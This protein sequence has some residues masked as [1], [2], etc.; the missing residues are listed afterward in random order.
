MQGHMAVRILAALVEIEEDQRDTIFIYSS[1]FLGGG[2]GRGVGRQ[3]MDYVRS[4]QLF[5]GARC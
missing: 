3:V 5:R 4:K 1:F 2:R